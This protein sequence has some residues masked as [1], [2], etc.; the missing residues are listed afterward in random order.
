MAFFHFSNQ[1]IGFLASVI[2]W[3]SGFLAAILSVLIIGKRL[4]QTHLQNIEK[5]EADLNE[6]LKS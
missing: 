3:L 4:A 1:K 2:S 5:L 6:S